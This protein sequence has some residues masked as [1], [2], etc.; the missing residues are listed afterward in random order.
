MLADVNIEVIAATSGQLGIDIAASA[1]PDVILLDV[2]LPDMRGDAVLSALRARP[3]TAAI[4]V[5]AVTADATDTQRRRMLE[6]GVSAYLT[7]PL[8]I[9]TLLA[10]IADTRGADTEITLK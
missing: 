4:P 9:D 8:D 2:N 10:A 7:K 6:L 5:I 1:R 3:Q